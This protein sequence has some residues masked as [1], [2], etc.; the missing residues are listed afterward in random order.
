MEALGEVAGW[1]MRGAVVGG[2]V[3]GIAHPTRHSE[4]D[5]CAVFLSG[6]GAVK[7]GKIS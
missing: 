5:G 1:L 4:A 2:V 3:G 6:A 7:A